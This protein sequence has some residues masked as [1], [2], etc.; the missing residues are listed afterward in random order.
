MG[1]P[2]SSRLELPWLCRTI[3][4]C[5]DLRSGWDLKRRCS[6]RWKLF[7]GVLH[8][9]CT[10]GHRVNSWSFVVGS[11]TASL[12]P[13]LSFDHNLCF[14][15]PNGSCEPI[16]NIYI[17]IYFQWYNEIFKEMGFDPCN[18]FLKIRE[19]TGTP[20]PNMGAHLGMWMFILTLSHTPGSLS[21]HVLLQTLALVVS[22]RLGLQH[23]VYGSR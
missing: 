17:S 3:T 11:Q 2:K 22:P 6:P 18:H 12:T 4:S 21:W 8:A 9:T 5:V 23:E 13:G 16:L 20:T 7:N 15:C 19:S 10:Q 1:V 14:R